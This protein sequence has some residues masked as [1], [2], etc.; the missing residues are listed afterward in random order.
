MTKPI[1]RDDALPVEVFVYDTDEW[2]M[3]CGWDHRC[4][5]TKNLSVGDT[6][7]L[8]VLVQSG[9]IYAAMVPV[10]FDDDGDPDETE[11]QYFATEELARKAA[12]RR[13]VR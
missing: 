7:E 12:Q 6:M 10:T 2:E 5:L 8:G 3:T 9:Y 13:P 1:T 11:V 4:E